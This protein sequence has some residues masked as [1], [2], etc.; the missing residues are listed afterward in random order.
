MAKVADVSDAFSAADAMSV[1]D[2]FG[3]KHKKNTRKAIDP[4]KR[5]RPTSVV[6]AAPTCLA[7]TSTASPDASSS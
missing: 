5:P 4:S 7:S 1:G 2:V 6:A 3:K